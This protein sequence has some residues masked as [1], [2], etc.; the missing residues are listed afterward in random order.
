MRRDKSNPLSGQPIQRMNHAPAL[1]K[2]RNPN[3]SVKVVTNTADETAGSTR[4]FLSINGTPAP[5]SAATSKFPTIATAKAIASP[6]LPFQ[7]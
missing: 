2:I 1:R 6:M 5:A 4:I 3:M 7:T